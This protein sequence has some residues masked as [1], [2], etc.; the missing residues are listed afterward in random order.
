MADDFIRTLTAV[1]KTQ[2]DFERA[3]AEEQN[4]D[5]H[6]PK[7]WKKDGAYYEFRSAS[8]SKFTPTQIAEVVGGTVT[9]QG[10]YSII[11]V[12]VNGWEAAKRKLK[13][14]GMWIERSEVA[15]KEDSKNGETIPAVSEAQARKQMEWRKLRLQKN[16]DCPTCGRG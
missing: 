8:G 5:D 16:P 14:A 1:N 4:Q 6:L 12:P 7:G 13:D 11:G 10:M 2:D 15:Q 3:K 9:K